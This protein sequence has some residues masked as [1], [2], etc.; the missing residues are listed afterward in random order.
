MALRG[1]KGETFPQLPPAPDDYPAFPDTSVWPVVFPDIPRGTNG[2]FARPPQHISHAVAPRIPPDQLPNHVAVVS[3][4]SG[5]G[6]GSHGTAELR[7]EKGHLLWR[8]TAATG[9]HYF[10]VRAVLRPT[11]VQRKSGNKS[12]GPKQSPP[13]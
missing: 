4:L 1:K 11:P 2:R 10:P 3:F 9:Q 5:Y 8:I 6:A 13:K 7:F 12:P